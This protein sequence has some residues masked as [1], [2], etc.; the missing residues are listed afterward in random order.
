MVASDY[1]TKVL[2]TGSGVVERKGNMVGQNGNATISV[3]DIE[4]L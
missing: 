3:M 1:N 4:V 2:Q